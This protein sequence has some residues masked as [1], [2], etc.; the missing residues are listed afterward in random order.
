MKFRV[1]EY[2]VWG[3]AEDGYEVN[4]AYYTDEVI[5]IAKDTTNKE[6]CDWLR[7]NLYPNLPNKVTIDGDNDF[8]LYLEAEEDGRP[9]LE[10]RRED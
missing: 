2:D 1:V 10:L 8:S 7:E 4:G 9:L 6:I 3:N 5:T